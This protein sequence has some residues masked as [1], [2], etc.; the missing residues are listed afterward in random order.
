MLKSLRELLAPLRTL[1]SRL[2][3]IQAALGRIEIR[4]LARDASNDFN[5]HEVRVFSQWGEDGLI[6][7]LLGRVGVAEKTFVEFG[8]ENY[9]ESNTRFLLTN[10]GW[11]GLVIDGSTEHVDFIERDEI[12]WRYPLKAVAAFVTRDN[13]NGLLRD[14]GVTK[15]LGL[16]SIDIDGNDYWVWEAIDVTPRI[17]VVEYNS[18]F[19][20][21]DSVTIPYQADFVRT[22]AHASNLYYGASVR[23]LAELGA[24]K[25]YALVGSNQAGNNLFFV[26]RDFIGGLRALDPADAW[27]PACFREMRDSEGRLTFAAHAEARAAIAHLPLIDVRDG[28]PRRVADLDAS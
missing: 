15:D 2:Q 4:Q 16:L 10:C 17:V 26:Q 24:R 27:R 6:Q 11:R 3:R 25:G 1:D 28:R 9:L 13:I 19:G 20:R 5:A 8:V 21:R 23:A 22:N 7:F 12:Y 14:N 18:L